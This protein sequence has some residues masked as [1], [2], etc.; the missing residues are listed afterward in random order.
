MCESGCVDGE[1][2]DGH[3]TL[4]LS[5]KEIMQPLKKKKWEGKSDTFFLGCYLFIPAKMQLLVLH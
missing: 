2:G 3:L 5:H 1:G 4:P